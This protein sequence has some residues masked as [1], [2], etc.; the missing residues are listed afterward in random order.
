MSDLGSHYNDL[1]FWA[2]NLDAPTKIEAKGPPPYPEIAPA[3]MSAT[4]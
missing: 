2:L 4:Y 1:P 3:T